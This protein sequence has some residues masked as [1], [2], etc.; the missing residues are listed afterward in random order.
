METPSFYIE[1]SW[2]LRCENP[3]E[4]AMRVQRMTEAF[5]ELDPLLQS[6]W[7]ADYL[8]QDFVPLESV[9]SRLPQIVADGVYRDDFDEAE[10]S[11]GYRCGLRNLPGESLGALEVDVQAGGQRSP[12]W[13]DN[14][15]TIVTDRRLAPDPRL[16]SYPLVKKIFQVLVETFGATAVT[17]SY[18]GQRT[19]P[20]FSGHFFRPAW[21]VYLSADNAARIVPPPTV[22]SERLGDGGLLMSATEQAF[23][24][25]DPDHIAAGRAIADALQPIDDRGS[26]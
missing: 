25:N 12:G 8:E 21:M 18:F 19:D 1:A 4:I 26:L 2:G 9:K 24:M 20:A 10:P 23:D 22:L 11:S 16:V 15:V 7:V 17:A 14:V 6:W 5:A 3:T 13:V